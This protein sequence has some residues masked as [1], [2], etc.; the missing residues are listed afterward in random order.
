MNRICNITARENGR[1][2][3]SCNVPLNN[4][5]NVTI[6]RSRDNCLCIENPYVA[7]RHCVLVY[8]NGLWYVKNFGSN[9]TFVDGVLAK[10]FI[11]LKN[12]RSFS[13]LKGQYSINIS[14]SLNPAESK[15]SNEASDRNLEL[16]VIDKNN[17]T[18]HVYV[19]RN[20]DKKLSAG[21][22]H[23]NDIVL[24]SDFVS[25]IHLMI[26]VINQYYYIWDVGSSNGTNLNG[27]RIQPGE[28]HKYEIS[29]GDIIKLGADD[30]F[31]NQGVTIFVV[32]SGNRWQQ[33]A[34][35]LD[36]KITIGRSEDCDIRLKH[37]GASRKHAEIYY[38]TR[39][40]CYMIVSYGMNGT[41]VDGKLI[42]GSYRLN[43]RSTIQITNT[44]F[45]LIGNTLYYSVSEGGFGIEAI[46]L[47]RDVNTRSRTKRILNNVNLSIKPGEFVAIVGGSGC[48]KS[49]LLNALTGYERATEG[50]VMIGDKSLYDNYDY[51]KSLIGFVPQQDIVYDHIELEKMLEYT[52]KLRMPDDSS[53]EER[54]KRVYEVLEM[55]ELTDF[56]KSMVK[57]LSG[58]QRKRASI[59]VELLADPG[60]FFLDEPTSGLD[61]GTERKLMGTLRRLSKD[62]RKTVIMVTHTTLNLHMCDKIIFMG[63]SGKLCFCGEPNEA[64]N[65]FKVDNFVD[66]YNLVADDTEYWSR[67]FNNISGRQERYEAEAVSINKLVRPSFIKQSGVLISRYINIICNDKAR[68][69]LMLIEP[70]IM[71]LIIFVC[72]PESPYENYID[73]KNLLFTYVCCAIWIGIFNSVQE[74]CKERP[75][76]KRE[77]MTNLRLS[78]YISSKFGV[79]ALLCLIQ[80]FL[81][82]AVFAISVG[83]P[84]EGILL[85]TPAPEMFITTFLTILASSCMGLGLSAV[86]RNSDRAMTM[87]PFLL[88]VQLVFAGIIFELKGLVDLLSN[89][90]IS[91]WSISA[92]GAS[93]NLEDLYKEFQLGQLIVANATDETDK[94]AEM[95]E[96]TI[97]NLLNCWGIMVAFC[98]VL[99]IIAVLFLKNV[100][101]DSR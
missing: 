62:K 24:E 91:R 69:A 79:Q 71:G 29:A 60:L 40:S 15:N 75:I 37:V 9:G 76:L 51:F 53:S 17:G 43:N 95:F 8:S 73:T 25:N 10:D 42:K 64:L 96:H 77:Y 30:Y 46:A 1:I 65:F 70:I 80:S 27:A 100:S 67:V 35:S 94:T 18:Q 68:L 87:S 78:A 12:N 6:G 23:Q 101:K 36:N 83:L 59:A 99:C 85:G 13:L 90:T 54:K 33:K 11:P 58:G 89:I 66:I 56:S 50:S 2:I 92:L 19:D 34:L 93:A 32:E 38:D 74:I 45:C 28:K 84:E 61:P 63:K 81:L 41:L 44:Y 52:A 31:T 97:E 21:R 22:G 88:V 14:T 3:A 72:K 47:T 82:F 16:F 7:R 48:G 4:N 86:V 26:E 20:A 55:V 39:K 98:V 5:V 57:K 49:T